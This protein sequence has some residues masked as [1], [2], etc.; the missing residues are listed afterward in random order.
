MTDQLFTARLMAGIQHW[1]SIMHG[2]SGTSGTRLRER[3]ERAERYLIERPKRVTKTE[4][5]WPPISTGV[6]G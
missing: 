1:L 3:L 6:E 4:V 2:I 5:I